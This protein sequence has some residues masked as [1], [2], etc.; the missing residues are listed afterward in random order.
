V[1]PSPPTP[2]PT[3]PPAA[4]APA[5]PDAP[6]LQIA[7]AAPAVAPV[8]RRSDLQLGRRLFH[9]ANGVAIAS[10][11][12]ALFTHTEVVHL[13]GT[14]ACLVYIVDRVRVAYPEALA[15]APWV[16]RLFFRADE[17]FRESGMIPYAIAILLT[18]LTVP[19]AAA[20]I[21]IYTL[22]L[23]DPLSA[24]VG[25]RWGRRR[26]VPGK[27][28][29]GSLAF[30]AATALIAGAVL[31]RTAAPPAGTLAGTALLIGFAGA[32]FEM[33]PLRVD[34]NLTIPLFVGFTAWIVC[35]WLGIPIG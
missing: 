21:A 10:S 1:I 30:L 5:P 18:I 28:V 14:I 9:A 32:V 7:S 33:L 15:R 27:S 6:S 29:E 17:Q 24:V 35:A 8:A 16:N 31:A 23:S 2:L 12:A 13:F 3:A 20:L 19:K 4:P 26:I 11:Y 34:D 25:I 22:A